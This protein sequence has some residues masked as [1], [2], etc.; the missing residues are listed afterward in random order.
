MVLDVDQLRASRV[1]SLPRL[2]PGSIL[3]LPEGNAHAR[4]GDCEAV[5]LRLAHRAGQNRADGPRKPSTAEH[6]LLA[7]ATPGRLISAESVKG[8]EEK[9]RH[10]PEWPI[11]DR[12]PTLAGASR[13]RS[14]ADSGP[15]RSS[16]QLPSSTRSESSEAEVLYGTQQTVASLARIRSGL[17]A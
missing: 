15:L 14:S 5:L 12:F 9:A 4:T 2:K 10:K 11:S 16:A 6:R 1:D 17:G 8:H 13:R 3:G 7:R